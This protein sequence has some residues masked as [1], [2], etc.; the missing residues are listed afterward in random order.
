MP[1]FYTNVSI[2]GK[3]LLVR[4]IKDGQRYSE[5]V[6]YQPYLYLPSKKE[7]PYRNLAG[8]PVGRI[9]FGDIREAKDFIQRYE[10]V[11]GFSYYGMD[12]WPYVYIHDT[13]GGEI[14]FDPSQI[15][16]VGIDI[17]VDTEDGYPIIEEADKKITAIAVRRGKQ[18]VAF[19][20]GDF[21]VPDKSVIYIKCNDEIQ[22]LTR[23]LMLWREYDPDVITG[24]NVDGFDIPYLVNRISQIL[25]EEQ[26]RKLSPWGI[27]RER[28]IFSHGKEATV[29]IPVGVSVLDYQN[30][31]KKFSPNQQSSYSLNNI[32][33]VEL[34]EKKIDYSE[35]SGLD[36]LY[37]N[38]HQK[39]MEY[40]I[41]DVDLIFKLEEKLGYISL[42]FA[43]A[44]DAKVNYNDAFTS[45]LLWDVIIYNFLASQ[46]IVIPQQRSVSGRTL[47]GGFVKEVP[48]G[49]Y[50]WVMSFDLTSLYPHL[51]IQYN[52]S[53][54]TFLGKENGVNV[55][56]C[57]EGNI[58]FPE[59]S[60]AANGCLYRKD[61]QGFLGALMESQFQQRA[62]YRDL[63]KAAKKAE[64]KNA[65]SKYDRAQYAKKIQLNSAYGATANEGFR[66][67]DINHAEAITMSGQLSIRYM[68]DEVNQFMNEMAGTTDVDYIVAI[69]TDSLYI[70]F[71]DLVN[72]NFPDQSDKKPIVDWLD[73][74]AETKIEPFMDKKYGELAA[75][76]NAYKQAMKMKREIIADKAIW[77]AKKRYMANMWDKEGERYEKPKLKIMGIETARSSTPEV[78]RKALEQ[79]ISIIMNKDEPTLQTYIA[80]FKKH[81]FTLPFDEVAFP[82]GVNGLAKYTDAASIY[83][84]GTPIHVKGSL[85]YNN[86]VRERKLKLLPIYEG[87]KIKFSYLIKPNPVKDM[88]IAAPG[89]LPFDD[90]HEYIDYHT[91]FEK[92]FL[93]PLN[94]ILHV[95]GWSHKEEES[96][97]GLFG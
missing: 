39:F 32:S 90:I 68:A 57:L 66:Y 52:I 42:V 11:D 1:D 93:D 35:Y 6:R 28:T 58:D 22:L 81:F 61:Q 76:M 86:L 37:K 20:Y 29:Y 67:F 12:R 44:Y 85:L 43:M 38:N 10:G 53:P 72:K 27:L 64:N 69:D 96:L 78:C 88:V 74:L 21:K 75:R 14:Q 71:K 47:T 40:N 5:K 34:K 33:H 89:F 77:T 16:V 80:E 56:T 62:Q 48:P 83:R 60:M 87:D 25:G 9:D 50:E 49:M 30:L 4:G 46:N 19:G 17:E 55:D 31:Y 45:V 73:D 3:N 7:T 95:I 97:K 84:K 18:R 13:Y 41:R 94:H 26:S 92:S 65:E 63:V 54:E 59:H 23:F 8:Q 2:H 70:T 36:D 51:I 91:Q 15:S 82:R 79:S 24:W